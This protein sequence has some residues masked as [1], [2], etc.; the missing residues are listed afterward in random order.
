MEIVLDALKCTTFLSLL[1]DLAINDF[2]RDYG[3]AAVELCEGESSWCRFCDYPYATANF[4]TGTLGLH[5]AD[6][7][8]KIA[9]L[10]HRDHPVV[11]GCLGLGGLCFG[12]LRVVPR[13]G[14]AYQ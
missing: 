9:K 14:L 6:S 8:F 7:V 11:L 1:S 10:G 5:V 2:E 12:C 13:Q 4:C 3:Q